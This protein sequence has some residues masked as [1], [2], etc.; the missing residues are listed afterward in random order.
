MFKALIFF[1]TVLSM[2]ISCVGTPKHQPESI[3]FKQAPYFF[4]AGAPTSALAGGSY[5]L[6]PGF[7]YTKE[8][9]Y[10]W[11]KVEGESFKHTEWENSRNAFL[12]DG[13]MANNLSFRADLPAGDWQISLWYDGGMQDSNAVRI[14]LNGVV[15]DNALQTFGEG[16]EPRTV[17]Q[18]MYRVAQFVSPVKSDG[19]IINLTNQGDKVRLLGLSLIPVQSESSSPKLDPIVAK[20]KDVGSFDSEVD[21]KSVIEFITPYTKDSEVQNFATYYKQQLELLAEGEKYFYYRG[22]SHFS[23]E[24]GLSLFDHIKQSIMLYDAVLS[25]PKAS[26]GLLYERALWYRTRLLYWLWLE[27]AS[28]QE[29]ISALRDIK[30]MK[31][32]QPNND[33]VRMY[34]G[35][36]ID[37]PDRFDNVIKPKN[38]PEWSFAQWELMNRLKSVV[39]WWVNEQ[40]SANGEFGGKFGDD[41]EILRWWSP[42]ILSGDTTTY[43]GW[44]RLADGVWNSSKVYKGYAKKPSDVEHS[45]EFISDT[46]PL[47]VL[48]SDDEEYITRLGYSADYF[49]NLWT[50]IN[51]EGFRFFKSAWFSSTEIE[52]EAPKN[53]DVSY[54]ARAAKA[55]R[56]YAWKSNDKATIKALEEW[57]DA[58]F[59]ASQKTT[60]GK[61]KGIIPASIDFPTGEINGPEPTWYIANMY[62]DYFDWNG[63]TAILDELLYTWTISGDEKYL[64]PITQHLDLVSKHR[65]VLSQ[66]SDIF[67]KGSEEWA[68]S[69]LGKNPDFWSVIGTWRLLTGNG[70]YDNLILAHGSSFVKY[71]LSENEKFLV[72]GMEP[73]LETVRYN[74]PM[75][76]SEVI[77]TDRVHVGPNNSRQVDILQAMV[78]GY[79]ITE[80]SSPYI[81]TSWENASRDMT[82][83]VTDSDSSKISVELYSYSEY[84]ENL[85]MRVW[86]LAPGT[87][88]LTQSEGS[89]V[90][91]SEKIQISKGGE[92]FSLT[93]PSKQLVK[94]NIK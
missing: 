75:I 69:I 87:Y 67:E 49:Q 14:V 56:Y 92:R 60:K 41:V 35:E 45:S 30:T 15:Q 55:V 58:W 19:L 10:G 12:I 52:T 77:H 46:A 79:G 33:L 44:K 37:T 62:W 9:G 80:S 64:L 13:I 7:V 81:A 22:W 27:G 16:A 47:M 73:Y 24:T 57:A 3:K 2:P 66:K 59:A 51:D 93:I 48:Y 5:P 94:I 72:E 21:I 71:R 29:K 70:K 53:R 68:V 90:V 91:R 20:L 88:T 86:Q 11:L 76:S 18:K 74:T 23:E 78:T 89:K 82:Y 8:K 85:T 34:N 4:D 26:E 50:G 54:N 38:A 32:L 63:S 39:D 17:I 36:Q 25:S 6:A 43:I 28:G 61:P 40:Q 31:E 83:L 84:S 65:K 1:L 42:L